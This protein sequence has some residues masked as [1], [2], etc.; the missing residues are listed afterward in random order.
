MVQVVS[1]MTSSFWSTRI[2]FPGRDI[3]SHLHQFLQLSCR[4]TRDKQSLV[5]LYVVASNIVHTERR[6]VR[7]LWQ[8]SLWQSWTTHCLV[9]VRDDGRWGL[10]F[11]SPRLRPRT[12][13]LRVPAARSSC[14]DFLD[15]LW[16]AFDDQF[17]TLTVLCIQ[18][19]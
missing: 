9:Q 5:R 12:R 15:Y 19:H 17:N 16:E 4:L 18:Q 1:L 13:D 3:D 14:E 6:V 11:V 7:I 2:P 8:C 10:G